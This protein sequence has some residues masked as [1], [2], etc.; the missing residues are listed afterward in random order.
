MKRKRL[1]EENYAEVV[2]NSILKDLSFDEMIDI[3][4]KIDEFWEVTGVYYVPNKTQEP[5]IVI[6]REQIVGKEKSDEMVLSA[7]GN[8]IISDN[9][10]LKYKVYETLKNKGKLKYSFK[11]D[12]KR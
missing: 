6:N 3:A 12:R 7:T 11:D 1:F 8:Y 2:K 9:S 10:V 5:V 4:T